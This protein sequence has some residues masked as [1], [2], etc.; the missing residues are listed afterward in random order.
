MTTLM[1]RVCAFAL[2]LSSLACGAD[3]ERAPIVAVAV[4]DIV[5]EH[6]PSLAVEPAQ[7]LAELLAWDAPIAGRLTSAFGHRD[8]GDSLLASTFH[9]AVDVAAPMGTPVT[10]PVKLRIRTIAYQA[11]AGR[12]VIADVV[13]AD[14]AV[15]WRL[16][17]A[18]LSH[19]AVFEGD[20]LER[21]ETLGRIG[22]S[23]SA[24]GAHLHFRVEAVEGGERTAVD[25]LT[26][27][28]SLGT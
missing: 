27:I 1:H 19:V 10:A 4:E 2:T 25:P 6:V 28:P 13:N 14:G 3:E 5:V 7:T 18:H 26:A 9:D 12:Y 8:L 21:G 20:V 24:T 16:T 22:L 17:F 23:G 11:R 15:E